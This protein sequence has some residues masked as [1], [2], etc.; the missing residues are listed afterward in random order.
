MTSAWS[1]RLAN[2]FLQ[3][4]APTDVVDEI[5]AGEDAEKARSASSAIPP[6]PPSSEQ[7]DA[8]SESQRK[9]LLVLQ[10]LI[11]RRLDGSKT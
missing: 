11:R 5:M 8:L 10:E 1:T 6:S 7:P 3:A 2:M 4:E 9:E